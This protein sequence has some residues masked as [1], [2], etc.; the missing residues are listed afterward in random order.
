MEEEASM[1]ELI[2]IDGGK[3]QLSSA[4]KSLDLLGLRGKISIVGIAKRLEE[5]YFP[6]DPVPLYLDKRSES[7]K[8]LQRARDEAHRFGITF[9]RQK[10]SKGSLHSELDQIT[11]VGP[12]TRDKLL[13]HFKS[14]KRI[15]KASKEN[16]AKVLGKLNGDKVYNGLH[17]KGDI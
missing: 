10:R 13:G 11:G 3:G 6:E 1:P 9:H 7:L 8:I 4:V 12:A 5:I 16:L 15:K 2:V 17:T 14:L